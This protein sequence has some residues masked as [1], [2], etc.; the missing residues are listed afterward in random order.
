MVR[1]RRVSLLLPVSLV[2]LNRSGHA[3]ASARAPMPSV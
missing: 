3:G 1:L 2:V